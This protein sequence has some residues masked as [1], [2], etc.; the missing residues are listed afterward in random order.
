MV[1]WQED[2]QEHRALWRSGNHS[3]A[4]V[5]VQVVDDTIRADQA[6]RLACEGT[7]LLWRGDFQNARQLL[8]AMT[9]RMERKPAKTSTQ[10]A[11]AF[12]LHRQ[13]QAQRA[14]VLGM[15]LVELEADY[16]IAL[17]R[18]PDAREACQ[19]VYGDAGQSSLI[20]LRELQGLIGACEWRKKG[21][22]VPALN[23]RIHPYYGVFSPVRGEY[24]DLVAQAPLPDDTL[25]FDIGTGSGV[26][27]AVLARRGVKKVLATDQDDRAL[28]CAREN[29]QRLG[30]AQQVELLACN[31][32]PE[33]RAPLIVCNPPWIPA[34][35]NAAIEY[36]IYDPDSAMLKGFLNGVVAH[37]APGGEAWLI[38]SDIAEHLGLRSRQQ[39]LD[40]IAN[41]GLNVRDRLDIKPRHSRAHDAS[42]PLH[43]A[44]YAEVTSLWRL[45]AA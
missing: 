28:A 43:Q 21:V 27:A 6:Y 18:A 7:A 30:L 45:I 39:L 17:R 10:A 29:M 20:S 3:K 13:A 11:E 36:A 16:S 25:A 40:M 2:A 15:L 23:A 24:V 33:G 35:P 1:V 26:L 12:H 31:L 5:R 37:L 4:P 44:R 38:L 32:F 8:Q 9:R 14:R 41:A 22:E 19:Q 34:R 42:D